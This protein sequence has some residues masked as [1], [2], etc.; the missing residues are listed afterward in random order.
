[1]KTRDFLAAGNSLRV[2]TDVMMAKAEEVEQKV[3]NMR[4]QLAEIEKMINESK[5]HWQGE[6]GDLH[7]NL[8]YRKKEEIDR[9][10]NKLAQHPVN[11][12]RAAR[13]YAGLAEDSKL[14]EQALPTN[15]IR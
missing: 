10:V 11:L 9:I 1:M 13:V 3:R 4:A 2:N 12:R 8:Y 14:I 15:V 7:R 5:S 6:A